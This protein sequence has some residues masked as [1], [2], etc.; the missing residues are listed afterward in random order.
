[1]TGLDDNFADKLGQNADLVSS[2]LNRLLDQNV[3][4]GEIARPPR[5]MAAIR[6]GVLNGGKRLRPF[7]LIETAALFGESD[8]GILRAACALECLH[9]YSLIHDDLPCMDDDDMRRGQPTVHKAFDEAMAVLAGD[10]LLTFAFDVMS[11][12]LTT[13]DS[14]I[15]ILL[16]N[17]LAR[18]AGHGGMI[19]GQ[20]L[21][22]AAETSILD[23][24][25]ILRLQSMKTGALIGYSIEAGAVIG[26]ASNEERSI[27][28]GFG[29]IIGQAFQL[30]DD[31][32]DVTASSEA[33]GKATGKDAGRGKKTLVDF[34]GIEG[35]Q[36]KLGQLL[37]E[38]N[39]L[40]DPFG[41]RADTLRQTA[42]FIIERKH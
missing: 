37:D 13:R 14:D 42:K 35:S 19:G 8:Q 6:H 34:Y 30:A 11:D 28:V 21:D 26:R 32:L 39:L 9:C 1:M 7:L 16:V 3:L 27:L 25:E 20:V 15:R 12:P 40:L 22:I 2:E 5:L 41:A 31:L 24:S 4:D 23:E 33:L 17:L 10:A 36:I 29:Q 18:A 38:A